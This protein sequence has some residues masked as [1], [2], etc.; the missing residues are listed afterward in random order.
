M[1]ESW[2][3][4]EDKK[5]AQLSTNIMNANN[6]SFLPWFYSFL[7]QSIRKWGEFVL[8]LKSPHHLEL[9]QFASMHNFWLQIVFGFNTLPLH[10]RH[11]WTRKFCEKNSTHNLELFVSQCSV[12]ETK[13]LRNLAQS[14]PRCELDVIMLSQIGSGIRGAEYSEYTELKKASIA[15]QPTNRWQ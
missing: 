9:S 10:S 2:V 7:W 5:C 11:V 3:K 4:K 8:Q 1:W 15:W 13:S 6:Q 14:W 12:S